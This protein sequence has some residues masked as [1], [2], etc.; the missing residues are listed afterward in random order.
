MS[1]LTKE[2]LELITEERKIVERI[3]SGEKGLKDTLFAQ[4]EKIKQY[5]KKI[6]P[7]YKKLTESEK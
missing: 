2:Y 5:L 1:I 3:M 4:H 6:D 7:I